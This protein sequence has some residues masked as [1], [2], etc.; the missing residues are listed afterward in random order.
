[1][2]HGSPLHEVVIPQIKLVRA[3]NTHIK[4]T[5]EITNKPLDDLNAHLADQS[6]RIDETNQRIAEVHTDMLARIDVTNQRIDAVHSDS[7]VPSPS[8]Q[9][10]L[11]GIK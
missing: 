11:S 5:L 6:Y 1:M 3:E 8:R 4:T 10:R 9:N 2:Y 7:E